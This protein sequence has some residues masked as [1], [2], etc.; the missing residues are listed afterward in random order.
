M[1]RLLDVVLAGLGLIALL[2]LFVVIA[3]A[4]VLEDGG[5]PFFRQVRVGRGGRTFRIWKFRSMRVDAERMGG[6]LTRAGDPRVT[7]VGAVLRRAKLDELP[8]LLNVLAGDLSLVGP[9]PEVP[10][11]V[12][13]YTPEQARV[14]SLVPGITDPASLAYFDEERILAAAQDPEREYL[15]SLMPAKIR[16]NLEYAERASV[17]SDLGIILKTCTRIAVGERRAPARE[18]R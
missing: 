1:K 18:P 13:R 6:Q 16:M 8:Q 14:L 3:V 2:P 4:I 11:Y 10:R 17:L 15:E 7:R 5:G 12:A 9:R